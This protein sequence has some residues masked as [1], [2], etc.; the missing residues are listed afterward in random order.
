MFKA[1]ADPYQIRDRGVYGYRNEHGELMYSGSTLLTENKVDYNH[2]NARSIPGYDM[3]HFRT[4][5]E[6][7]PSWKFEW[8]LSP[9][10]CNQPMIEFC[11]QIVIQAMH[12]LHNIDKTPYKTSLNRQRYTDILEVYK[13]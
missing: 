8:I 11:E 9:R 6:S 13:G 2:R 1:K 5:L 4:M 12:P 7:N 10:K 3:T